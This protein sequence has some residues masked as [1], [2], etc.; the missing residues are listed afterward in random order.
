MAALVATPARIPGLDF[1]LEI[2]D[3]QN[4]RNTYNGLLD[5]ADQPPVAEEHLQKLAALFVRHNAQETLGLHL[6]HGHFQTSENTVML[7][8]NFQ[9]PMLRWTKVT[10][11]T[12]VDLNNIHGHI[13]VFTGS[14]FIAYEKEFFV[15]FV[16]Y[17]VTNDLTKLLG[18][19]VLMDVNMTM[20]ELILDQGTVMLDASVVRNCKP[21]RIT[22]W[23]FEAVDGEP[24]VHESNET[25][26]AMSSG[27]HKIFNAGKPLPK[28]E[29]VDDL[30]TS[31]VNVDVL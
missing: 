9:N 25:H 31:L 8:T 3:L 26:A 7:G 21:T 16:D 30:K 11:V 6:I 23:R 12:D 5:D 19:Q 14:G 1:P 15:D 29:N 2:K 17:L 20:W 10:R 24:R 28:L 13:F 18:L 27:N 4:S 22:G